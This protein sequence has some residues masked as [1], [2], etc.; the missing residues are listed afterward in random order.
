MY[1]GVSKYED[2]WVRRL[3]V[4]SFNDIG[5]QLESELVV[6]EMLQRERAATQLELGLAAAEPVCDVAEPVFDAKLVE[7]EEV[8][9]IVDPVLVGELLSEVEAERQGDEPV[10]AELR[11]ENQGLPA[12]VP[13]DSGVDVSEPCA[14]GAVVSVNIVECC[15]L[16]FVEESK[17]VEVVEVVEKKQKKWTAI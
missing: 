10:A 9:S 5:D 11:E 7:K 2:T 13:A 8:E 12:L 1:Q 4:R 3:R 14:C 17:K 16:S 6:E 15:A